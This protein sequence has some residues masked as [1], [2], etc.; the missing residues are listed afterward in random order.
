MRSDASF[1]LTSL[2]LISGDSSLYLG[3]KWAFH[4]QVTISGKETIQQMKETA[5]TY[6]TELFR[7]LNII[8]EEAYCQVGA[9]GV[10]HD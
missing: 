1:F 3:M 7:G 6:L 5:L 8:T 2:A 10:I 9:D 4:W